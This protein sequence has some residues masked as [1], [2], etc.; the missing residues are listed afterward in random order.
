IILASGS[1]FRRKMLEDAGLS[2]AVE[3]PEI[4]ERAAERAIEGSG[5]TPEDLA[6]ILAEAKALDVSQK[7]PG[8]LVIG[9]DHTPSLGDAVRQDAPAQQ[10]GRADA[11]WRN[12]LASCRRGAPDDARSR[13]R[14]HRPASFP[15]RRARA[16]ER[17][18]I[19]DRG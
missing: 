12:G 4:D 17:G 10:R 7:R 11:R 18:R 19:P 8:A 13:S 5:V 3:R 16:F 15:R 1:P 2:F 6:A 14:L 9:T